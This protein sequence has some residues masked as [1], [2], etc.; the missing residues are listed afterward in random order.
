[1]PQEIPDIF[2]E[3]LSSLALAL[4]CDPTP[5]GW[6]RW[7][8]H[9]IEGSKMKTAFEAPL[10]IHQEQAMAM[11]GNVQRVEA[12]IEAKVYQL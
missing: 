6:L 10:K 11:R 3:C 2:V 1:M 12:A 4:E 5:V 9:Q 8:F 7:Q